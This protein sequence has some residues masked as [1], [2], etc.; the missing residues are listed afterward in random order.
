[1]L[2]VEDDPAARDLVR[3]HLDEH[4]YRLT[5]AIDGESAMALVRRDQ[6]DLVLLDLG[7]AGRPSGFEMLDLLQADETLAGVPVIVVTD[8]ADRDA[9]VRALKRGAHDYLP[10][11]FDLI[12]LEARCAAAL[13]TKRLHDQLRRANRRLEHEALTDELT[14]LANR[15]HALE[16]LERA[17][18]G[19]RRHGRPLAVLI[20]DLDHFKDVNDTHGHAVGDA[21]LVESCRRFARTLRATDLI[22]RFGGDEILVMVS[23]APPVQVALVGDRLRRSI[24]GEP[25]ELGETTLELSASVGWA[26]WQ[27]EEVADLIKRADEALYAAKAAGRNAVH[28]LQ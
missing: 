24:C 11:P 15:R 23:E 9:L 28:P 14:G 1:V 5:A 4:G 2:L 10:K 22:A 18:A 17:A 19:S 3:R 27:G 20:V 6:P 25:F 8:S 12:E 16:E 26:L 21:V 13:R 7:L